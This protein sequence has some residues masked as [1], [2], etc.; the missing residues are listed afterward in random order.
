MQ[1]KIAFILLVVVPTEKTDLS[2]AYGLSKS[3]CM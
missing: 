2:L 1:W 3:I